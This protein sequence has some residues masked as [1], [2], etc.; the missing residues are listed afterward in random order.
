MHIQRPVRQYGSHEGATMA[1][2]VA[3]DALE[4]SSPHNH[5]YQVADFSKCIILPMGFRQN[6]HVFAGTGGRCADP[7]YGTEMH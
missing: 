1:R 6:I 2:A 5:A 7:Q 4:Q 3:I